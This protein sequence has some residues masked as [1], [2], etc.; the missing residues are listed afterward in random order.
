VPVA[1]DESRSACRTHAKGG[2]GAR[3][4]SIAAMHHMRLL[5]PAER[6][7]AF[8]DG[9][10]D[11]YRFADSANWVDDGALSLG[12]ASY[13][14]V[15]DG[16]ALIYD[17]HVSVQHARY[18]REALEERGVR[19]FT[20]VLSHWHLDHVAGTAAF[21][22]CEVIASAR[23]AELL[24]R[25][26][27]AIE[28]GELEGPPA[29]DPLVLPTRTFEGGLHLA[30]GR[31][32]LELI[33]TNIH[34]DDATVVWLPEQ[35]LLLC[36]DT[37]EDTITYVDEPQS[38]DLHLTNLGKLWRLAPDRILPN[39]GDPDVIAAGGYSRDLIRATEQYIH[40]LERCRR[41]PRLRNASLRELIAGSLEAGSTHY[42][43]PY[44]AV[45]RE[46]LEAVLAAA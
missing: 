3:R 15:A 33:H 41:E 13:A 11:G 42:F 30:I 2:S 23:T 36:G 22:D 8:Y 20:V 12:I 4:V 16:D 21:Q 26:K 25:H 40:A 44:E 43:A 24:A 35:R 9:R 29:I 34:S 27:S 14:V 7:F 1:W 10:I 32:Q 39:H 18:I 17:T 38:F 6:V 19:K 28:R 46:N 5:R 31:V 37:M 45:H